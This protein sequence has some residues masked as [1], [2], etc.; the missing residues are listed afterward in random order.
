[1]SVQPTFMSTGKGLVKINTDSRVNYRLKTNGKYVMWLPATE[2]VIYL[3]CYGIAIRA[4][5]LTILKHTK[6]GKPV[7][8][9]LNCTF[10]YQ[11]ENFDS[12]CFNSFNYREKCELYA[13]EEIYAI[14]DAAF[15]EDI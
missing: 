4:A 7:T 12:V 14:S 2:E 8:Y 9:D 6:A 11:F 10:G 13:L 5:D 15:L 1:M 3:N